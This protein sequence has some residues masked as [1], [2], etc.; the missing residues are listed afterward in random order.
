MIGLFSVF[1]V[2]EPQENYIEEL[3]DPGEYKI[4]WML[5]YYFS[6]IAYLFYI[7]IK[8][9]YF[10]TLIKYILKLLGTLFCENMCRL[11]R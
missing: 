7:Y 5:C 11:I 4:I 10:A 3:Y 2:M 9:A 1:G 6:F 8:Y